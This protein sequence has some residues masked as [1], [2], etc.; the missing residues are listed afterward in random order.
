MVTLGDVNGGT[1]LTHWR[2]SFLL[3]IAGPYQ[4]VL[5]VGATSTAEGGPYPTFSSGFAI[6]SSPLPISLLPGNTEMGL[7]VLQP[8]TFNCCVCVCV[9]S[10]ARHCE[11]HCE[12]SGAG[13]PGH[14]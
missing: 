4:L 3:T 14:R 2:C 6:A 11:L 5:V 10:K 12:W 1:L 7:W 9:L 8:A 13:A